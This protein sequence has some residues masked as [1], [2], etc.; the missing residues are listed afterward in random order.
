MNTRKHFFDATFFISAYTGLKV[1]E[2]FSGMAVELKLLNL[3]QAKDRLASK[4]AVLNW[5]SKPYMEK[6][7]E[8]VEQEEGV[9]AQTKLARWLLVLDNVESA[10][11]LK[12]YTP[13]AGPGSVLFTSR[14]PFAKHYLSPQSGM[15]L[16]PPAVK[17]RQRCFSDSRTPPVLSRN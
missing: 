15:D 16:R 14:D 1:D 3:S 4:A 17:M 11:L 8:T 6:S 9:F 7:S 5:L 13:L 2:S 12:E 10:T